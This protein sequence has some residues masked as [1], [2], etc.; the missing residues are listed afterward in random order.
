MVVLLSEYKVG[1][2]CCKLASAGSHC[3]FRIAALQI[4][5]AFSSWYYCIK[6]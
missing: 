1:I 4:T 6:S 5:V 2:Q 3:L